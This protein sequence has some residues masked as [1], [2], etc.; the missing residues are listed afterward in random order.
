MRILAYF[1]PALA[2][3][4]EEGQFCFL[5]HTLLFQWKAQGGCWLFVNQIRKHTFNSSVRNTITAM[6]QSTAAVV[7]HMDLT[8][9]LGLGSLSTAVVYL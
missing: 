7:Q 5:N 9:R 3:N 4:S 2:L 1:P 8:G 6:L